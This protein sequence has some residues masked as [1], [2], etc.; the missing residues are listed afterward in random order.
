MPRPAERPRACRREGRAVFT[1]GPENRS[2]SLAL[3]TR[4]VASIRDSSTTTAMPELPDIT[5]YLEAL[6]R[7]IVGQRLE[8]ALLKNPFLLRTAEPPLASAEGRQVTQLRRLGKR[9]A[10][11]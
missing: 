1:G 9:I 4:Q 10:I 8:H 11:G 5:A 7:R 3:T 2:R 6:E